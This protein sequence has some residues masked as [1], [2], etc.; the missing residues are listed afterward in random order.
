M[1]RV[2]IADDH[3]LVRTGLR[4]MLA[5][6]PGI[7]V[8]AEAASGEEAVQVVR[9]L[10]PDVIL[11]DVSMPGI[12][13]V[14]ACQRILRHAP[15]ARVIGLT[16]HDD[17]FHATRLL[18]AG[19]SGYLTKGAEA[20]EMG[21]AIRRVH[22]GQR[23]LTPRVAQELAL[24]SYAG[25]REDNPFMK[26]SE[27]ELQIA[28]MIVACERAPAIARRLFISPKTVN[29]YRYRIFDKLAIHSDVE[30]VHLALQHGVGP[31]PEA[32]RQAS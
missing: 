9:E 14:E 18:R 22:V 28:E 23:Y 2:L 11:L 26:L 10:D 6:E 7:E 3:C 25:E 29:T 1:I 20:Q 27:R 16:V 5:A 21:Q 8:V 13:G 30:L 12:G 4:L 31:A 17:E 15:E 19:A 32:A 24:S